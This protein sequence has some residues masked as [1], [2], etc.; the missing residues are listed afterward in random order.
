MA[1]QYPSHGSWRGVQSTN[2]L[3]ERWWLPNHYS[4]RG[5]ILGHGSFGIVIEVEGEDGTLYAVKR[6][7]MLAPKHKRL[8]KSLQRSAAK[9]LR[10]TLHEIAI[11]RRLQ[12]LSQPH[13]VN[14]L[15]AWTDIEAIEADS[16]TA[17]RSIPAVYLLFERL[18]SHP[19]LHGPLRSAGAPTL[20]ST[21]RIFR[22]LLEGVATLHGNGLLHRD[23]KPSNVLFTPEGTLRI[24]DF[25]MARP[26]IRPFSDRHNQ[27]DE[28]KGREQQQ[29]DEPVVG[30]GAAAVLPQFTRPD[31]TQRQELTSPSKGPLLDPMGKSI[32]KHRHLRR[33]YSTDVVTRSYC[34]PELLLSNLLSNGIT[35]DDGDARRRHTAPQGGAQGGP[36]SAFP[37]DPA[38]VLQDESS[39]MAVD[40]W[41]AGC[42]LGEMLV[43]TLAG[44][45]VGSS[46]NEASVSRALDS[47][48]GGSSTFPALPEHGS[49]GSGIRQR[50]MAEAEGIPLALFPVVA[51]C[52]D[53]VGGAGIGTGPVCVSDAGTDALS[54]LNNDSMPGQSPVDPLSTRLP[55]IVMTRGEDEEDPLDDCPS[56]LGSEGMQLATVLRVVGIP[57]STL[58]QWVDWAKQCSTLKSQPDA[59]QAQAALAYL[60]GLEPRTSRVEERFAALGD[61]RAVDLLSRLLSVQTSLRSTCLEALQHPFVERA[62]GTAAAQCQLSETLRKE[63]DRL[64]DTAERSDLQQLVKMIQLEADACAA[65]RTSRI[66]AFPV[67]QDPTY[68]I[69]FMLDNE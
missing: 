27:H 48:R 19:S 64:S 58:K 46:R 28:Q 57:A 38:L 1:S 16:A 17:R 66:K 32:L 2:G 13:I 34:A 43:R 12:T 56:L 40:A 6:V 53:G 33:R 15:D 24:I 8:A 7:Q 37:A 25:G 31:D 50:L 10:R 67:R 49:S 35:A 39:G 41:S 20:A 59:E 45:Q 3:E 5:S 68:P 21:A 60:E 30:T 29:H 55:D 42:I 65:Q 63:I 51:G 69:V 22:Q 44:S 9:T 11:L 54:S 18:Y 26:V 61:P 23:L 62:A 52:G 14:L 47:T 4:W 36:L